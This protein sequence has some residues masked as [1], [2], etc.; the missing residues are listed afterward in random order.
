M[1]ETLLQENEFKYLHLLARR[2][3]DNLKWTP[4]YFLGCAGWEGGGRTTIMF[5]CYVK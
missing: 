5:S 1:I 4:M 3:W 2:D